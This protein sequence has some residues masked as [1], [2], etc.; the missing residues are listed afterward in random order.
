M[1][2]LVSCH[3]NFKASIKLKPGAKDVFCAARPVPLALADQVRAELSRLETLGVISPCNTGV[4]NASPVVWVKKKNGGLRMCA[5]FKVHV[6]NKIE[7]EA[8]P[9]P[10]QDTVFCKMDGAKYFAKI[11]LS[12][13]Y[14]QIELDDE[15]KAIS[16]I[17]TSAGLFTLNRL[18]MG[19]KN[20]ASIF[21]KVIEKCISGLP[22]TV[23]YQ[24]D[25][26]VFGCTEASLRK[27]LVAVQNKLEEQGFTINPDKY[28]DVANKVSFLGFEISPSGI[29]LDRD[30]VKKILAIKPPNN[31]KEVEQFTGMVIFFDGLYRSCRIFCCL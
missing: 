13:A 22:G 12:S 9:L 18:Q 16:V 15:A 28:V 5:N 21:Q 20:A 10:H 26:L 4:A 7:S 1:T 3:K 24:D 11:D 27:W 2:N 6:N 25:I 19:M 8:Y 23:A 29:R 17:N 14:W 30:L 31:I